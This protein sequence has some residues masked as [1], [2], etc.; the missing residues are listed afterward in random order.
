M[1]LIIGSSSV[2]LRVESCL[3]YFLFVSLLAIVEQ[4][5]ASGFV[6][7]PRPSN[8]QCNSFIYQLKGYFDVLFVVVTTY[9]LVAK[10][11]GTEKHFNAALR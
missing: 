9:H 11:I 8:T 10:I 3:L 6:C 4:R 2:C 5:L 1:F 7:L